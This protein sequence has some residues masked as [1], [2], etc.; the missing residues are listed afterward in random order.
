M[1]VSVSPPRSV[2]FPRVTARSPS[3]NSPLTLT[4]FA[5]D[6]PTVTG[7]ITDVPVALGP[8]G[9]GAVLTSRATTTCACASRVTT[10]SRGTTN[11]GDSLRLVSV[12]RAKNPG[13]I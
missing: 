13:Q 11:C 10:A 5:S 12:A 6:R 8:I 1:I 9:P 2:S 7:T 4:D 3:F